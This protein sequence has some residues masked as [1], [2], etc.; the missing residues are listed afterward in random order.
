[1]R[2]K[3]G[4]IEIVKELISC[5]LTSMATSRSHYYKTAAWLVA[6]LT[7][8][9]SAGAST[10]TV[11]LPIGKL[12]YTI[13][14]LG[15]TLTVEKESNLN[16]Y[17][18]YN[19]QINSNIVGDRLG[20]GNL[21]NVDITYYPDNNGEGV[22][23]ELTLEACKFLTCVDPQITSSY[24]RH[25]KGTR[26]EEY[27]S[28]EGEYMPYYCITRMSPHKINRTFRV[29]Q[30]ITEK[31]RLFY[32]G[33]EFYV[34][35]DEDVPYECFMG[36][37]L[38]QECCEE[39][40][41]NFV[42]ALPE[43]MDSGLNGSSDLELFD[44]LSQLL[45][46]DQHATP[47]EVVA[48]S[49]LAALLAALLGGG[50]LGG[51]AGGAGG[52]GGA[53][54]SPIESGP[55]GPPPIENPYQGV[56]DKY[57]THHPDGSIT[58]KDPITGEQ[59][60]YLPDGHGGYDNP[61]G[62]GYK[63]KEDMLN[64][65]AYLDRN[66]YPLSQDAETAARN[67][68][69]QREQWD[70]QNVRDRERGYSD[71]M[72]DYRDWVKQQE[73]EI[74]KEERIAKLA[75]EYGVEATEEA[76]KRAIKLD[77][78]QAGIESAKQEAEA[79]DNN[80]VVV[81]L[82]STKNVAATSLV[83]IPM[84][85]SGVGTV[86]AA[87]MANAKL[88]QSGFTFADSVIT[89]VGDAYVEGKSIGKA[90]AHG[91]TE[92]LVKV[93]QNYAGEI[94]GAAAGKL[95]GASSELVKKGV[96]LGTEATVVIGGRGVTDGLDEYAESG[97]LSKALDKAKA[98]MAEEAQKHL[99][100]KA[101]EYGIDKGKEY[102][103]SKMPSPVESTRMKADTAAKTVTTRQQAVTRTQQQVSSAKQRVTNAQQSAQRTQQKLT[104]AQSKASSA[105][106]NLTNAN[107]RVDAAQKQ[108]SQA[109]TPEAKSRAEAQ[110]AAAQK[111]AAKAQ[112]KYEKASSELR[113]ADRVNTA[114]QRAAVNAEHDLQ[115]AQMGAQKAQS[116]LKTATA[117]R[118]Q[119]MRDAWAAEQQAQVDKFNDKKMAHMTGNDIVGGYRA[120]EEHLENLGKI[121]KNNK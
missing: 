71:D 103:K 54:P 46:L 53:L 20:A 10:R 116:D 4:G 17:L 26:E 91:V 27:R 69:E 94:G 111:N 50:G 36:Y 105:S 28:M 107:K 47:E 18:L 61:L 32:I 70:A 57:V 106:K 34:R 42:D 77:Q 100:N 51:L 108:L 83:L 39:V 73:Y 24:S 99:V 72:A 45:G 9:F 13:T 14:N 48:I 121:D 87:T 2:P 25:F 115:K 86:S 101:A 120:V 85:L 117:Q 114:T 19:R 12:V 31:I 98:G 35:N 119:A 76:V 8:W 5:R 65:L 90:A 96:E 74:K 37:D 29:N 41:V 93:A 104:Q 30:D 55:G 43:A 44:T 112:Q 66:R 58:I 95:A 1:M 49:M 79:A 118:D 88:V 63:S 110:L 62:G 11:Q 7:C 3:A 56:E 67:Q 21:I 113:T 84:A 59:K 89:K 33:V 38:K 22:C 75:S 6:L 16:H 97:D 52:A 68:A 80:V 82:E 92:G 15:D 81:G 102:I 78:I 23:T 60:L 64:H 109:K 40:Y